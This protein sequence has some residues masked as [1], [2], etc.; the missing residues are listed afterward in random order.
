MREEG[1]GPF[2]LLEMHG[3][4]PGLEVSYCTCNLKRMPTVSWPGDN[5]SD[6]LE[7]GLRLRGGGRDRPEVGEKKPENK[8][9][10]QK[11]PPKNPRLSPPGGVASSPSVPPHVKTEGRAGDLGVLSP[12]ISRSWLSYFQ[13]PQPRFLWV[14]RA[15]RPRLPAPASSVCE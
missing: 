1:Q 10:Q 9:Q 11:K 5:G 6:F 2:L 15:R 13:K 12:P 3:G 14:I 7:S 4:A 8:N